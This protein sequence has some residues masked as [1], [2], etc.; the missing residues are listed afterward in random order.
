[1]ATTYDVLADF[2]DTGVQPAAG[3]PFTYGTETTLNVGFTLLPYFGTTN[4]SG[5][6]GESTDDGTMDNWYFLN[7]LAGSCVGVVAT[8][9]I[10]TFLRLSSMTHLPRRKVMWASGQRRHAAE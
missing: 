2:N 4:T 6:T 9:E 3:Y 1:M 7:Q 8:G 5:A 10:L